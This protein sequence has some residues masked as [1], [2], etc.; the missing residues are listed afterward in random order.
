MSL[1]RHILAFIAAVV[2]HTIPNKLHR[3]L[4][5]RHLVRTIALSIGL[6]IAP[7]KHVHKY[8]TVQLIRPTPTEAGI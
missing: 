8:S 6:W 3:M 1:S 2:V 4:T 7:S 5:E